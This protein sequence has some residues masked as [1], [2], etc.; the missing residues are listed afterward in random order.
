MSQIG[1]IAQLTFDVGIHRANHG[2][3]VAIRTLNAEDFAVN[4]RQ[5]ARI[6]VR[7]T[8]DHHAIH[9]L[10]VRFGLFER[11]NAAVNRHRQMRKITLELIHA[12]VIQ[13]RDLTVFFRAKTRQPG[14]ACVDDKRLTFAFPGDGINEITQEFVA[15]LIVDSDTRFDGN[16]NRHHVAHRFNAVSHQLCVAHQTGAKHAI[17]HAIGRTTHIEVNFVVATRFCK[18][19]AFCQCGRIAAAKLQRHRM[20]FFAIGQIVSLTVNDR[21]GGDHFG[22]QQRVARQ[23]AQEVATMSVR[24]VEHRRDGE[25]VCRESGL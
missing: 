15:V 6:L 14:F 3:R 1:A 16:R 23:L 9:M 25:T 5:N 24:P 20:L 17:L 13:R 8:P 21:S 7:L 12:R 18:L 22:V 19:C 4:R 11:F 10:Q 2:N